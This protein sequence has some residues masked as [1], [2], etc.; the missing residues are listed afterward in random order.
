MCIYYPWKKQVYVPVL[1]KQSIIWSWWTVC[2]LLILPPALCLA[3]DFH[4]VHLLPSEQ[5]GLA[6]SQ[7]GFQIIFLVQQSHCEFKSHTAKVR[8]LLMTPSS[9]TTTVKGSLLVSN[10]CQQK[11]LLAWQLHEC[12]CCLGSPWIPLLTRELT[13]ISSNLGC[14]VL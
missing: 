8:H 11:C 10:K 7:P 5:P 2:E 12:L 4:I 9:T 14:A 3:L 13:Q 1:W 6:L